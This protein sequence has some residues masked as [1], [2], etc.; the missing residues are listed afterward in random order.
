[1]PA[2]SAEQPALAVL[3][4]AGGVDVGA[5]R[6]GECVMA[7]HTVLLAAFLMQPDRPAGAARPEILDLHLQRRTDARKAVSEGGHQRPVP[8]IAERRGRN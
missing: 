1:V 8:Q 4:D 7:R 2:R 5:Q 3:G 6:L